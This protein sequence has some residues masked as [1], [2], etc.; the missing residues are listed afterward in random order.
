MTEDDETLHRNDARERLAT[1][2]R[3]KVSLNY[4]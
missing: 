2:E 3:V 4:L 1:P